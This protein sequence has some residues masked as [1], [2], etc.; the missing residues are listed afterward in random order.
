MKTKKSL[1]LFPLLFFFLFTTLYGQKE[2]SWVG[3]AND[4]LKA[5]IYTLDNGLKVYLTVYQDAPRIQCYIPVKVGSKNDPKETTG[6]AHYFEHMMFKGTPHFGT[7]NWNEE[8]ILIQQIEDLFEVYRVET[9]L[10]KRKKLYHQIDS[11]SYIASTYAI[12]NEYDKMMKFLGSQGTN[13]GTSNDYTIYIENIPSNQLENWAK[14]QADRFEHPVLRLFHTELETVYEEKNMSLTNDSR[15]VNEAMLAALFPNHP[16]GQQTTL[17]DAEHLKNPS[18]KKIREFYDRYYVP[19]N[20]AICLS[21]DFDMDEAIQIIDKYFGKLK[22]KELPPFNITNEKPITQPIVDEVVGLEAEFVRLAFRIGEPANSKE[23]YILNMLDLILSNGKSG[24]ID[25]NLNQKQVVYGASAFAYVL[26]DNS[27]YMLHGVPKTGQTLEEVKD[28]LLQQ[29]ELIKSGDFDDKLMEAAINN[30][31]LNEMRQLESNQARAMWMARAFMNNIPWEEACK[32]IE[33]Y[34][35]ITK[36]DVVAFA[37]KHFKN[38]YIVIYKRQGTPPEANKVEKPPITPIHV[39]R[40]S[41]SD[42][43]K[44]I[45]DSKSEE[46]QPLFVDYNKEITFSNLKNVPIYYIQNKEN[47]TFEIKFRFKAGEL[48]NLKLPIAT[49]Y[50]DYLGT[51]KYTAAQVKEEFYRLACNINLYCSDDYSQLTLSGLSDN[52]EEALKLALHVVHN[53][54]PDA[55][56]LTN[57]TQ[58]IIKQRNDAKSNQNSVLNALITYCEYGAELTHYMLTEKELLALTGSELI[59]IIKELLNYQPEIFYY[60]TASLEE[61]KTLLDKNY[62]FPKTFGE[63]PTKREFPLQEV[64][65]NQLFFAPYQAKQARLVTY[66][67]GLLF[68]K[69]LYPIISMY[70]QYFGGGMNAIVFQEMREKRSLAYSAQSRYIIPRKAEDFTYN[71]AFIATQNDKIVDAFTAFNSLFNDMPVS[72]TAFELAKEGAKTSIATNRITKNGI[73]NS[74]I[75]NRELGY[76]YDYRK[77]FYDAIDKFNIEDI[78]AFNQQYIKEKPKIYMVLSNEDDVNFDILSKNFGNVTKL[79]LED[80]FGY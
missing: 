63:P 69:T 23:I 48:N 46:I 42:F 36:A 79:S 16:Y 12:P 65:Q 53:A 74:F 22:A 61:L 51:D 78:I 73:L 77:D 49:Q 76:N 50:F 10:E 18:M 17:G 44:E 64:T 19:N 47:R 26:C 14:I 45:K 15:K 59:G 38:N 43:F 37:N 35:K 60:G 27:S 58:D 13:A 1:F 29:I 5:R 11:I 70:N 54:I 39:N 4:P 30:M 68:D 67:R 32:S 2:F 8:K 66:S 28:L 75:R 41:E 3:V 40:D 57:L 24:L 56:A 62:N 33:N 71:Y 80:I 25:L 7:T 6:L 9:D 20:M 55:E 31:K 52:F 34:S 72:P 21:G